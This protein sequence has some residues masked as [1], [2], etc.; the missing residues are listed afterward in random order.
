MVT[1]NQPDPT[2]HTQRKTTGV[3]I[4]RNGSTIR[5]VRRT[6]IGNTTRLYQSDTS[7]VDV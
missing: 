3:A 7:F 1:A 5:Y 6:Q 2:V 4:L